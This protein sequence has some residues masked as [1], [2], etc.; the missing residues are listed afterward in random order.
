MSVWPLTSFSYN[1]IPLLQNTCLGVRLS[2]VLYV[3]RSSSPKCAGSPNDSLSF[4]GYHYRWLLAS[5][6]PE[7]P[8]RQLLLCHPQ[9]FPPRELCSMSIYIFILPSSQ[10]Q[11][12]PWLRAPAQTSRSGFSFWLCFFLLMWPWTHFLTSL[13]LSYLICQL[14]ENNNTYSIGS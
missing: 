3:C 4:Q 9:D 11:W 10:E 8:D 5:C 7:P 13:N 14:W 6:S 2:C 12:T 1:N